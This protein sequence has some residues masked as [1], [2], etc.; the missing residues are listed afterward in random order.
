MQTWQ[1][2]GGYHAIYGRLPSAQ[3]VRHVR[4][5]LV[6]VNEYENELE[7]ERKRQQE[8]QEREMQRNPNN[9]R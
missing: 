2:F 6:A 7:E 9:R 8:E 1:A 4:L 5:W 3:K